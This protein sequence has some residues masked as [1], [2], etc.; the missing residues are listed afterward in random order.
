MCWRRPSSPGSAALESEGA[1]PGTPHPR[2][3]LPGL[4][5]I[6]AEAA[7]PGASPGPT[8]GAAGPGLHGEAMPPS[9]PTSLPPLGRGWW[10]ALLRAWSHGHST[11]VPVPTSL[12]PADVAA[13]MVTPC[14]H[15]ARAH[16]HGAEVGGLRPGLGV[17]AKIR[18]LKLGPDVR[19][20]RSGA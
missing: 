2:S 3:C 7:L 10:P 20:L 9:V 18:K 17:R 19:R 14:A 15:P 12:S 4:I 13:V 11:E 6:S 1:P 5:S 16:R 8:V